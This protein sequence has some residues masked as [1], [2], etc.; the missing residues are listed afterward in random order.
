MQFRLFIFVLLFLFIINPVYAVRS[1]P[2]GV[3]PEAIEG[4]A[5]GTFPELGGATGTLTFMNIG[6]EARL[7]TIC[8]DLSEERTKVNN[9]T[10]QGIEASGTFTGGPDGTAVFYTDSGGVIKLQL[11]D[12]KLFT[13]TTQGISMNF[14]VTDPT[15]FDAWVEPVGARDSGARASDLSGQVEIACPPDLEAWDVMKMGRVIYV[16][17][18]I[19]TGEYIFYD[20]SAESPSGR[21]NICYDREAL[22]SRK[23]HKPENSAIDMAEGIGIEILTAE[24]YKDLQKL[25]NFDTKTSSWIKTPL[26]IRKLGGALFADR[27]YNSVFVYHNGAESYYNSRGFRGSLRV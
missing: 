7:V 15:I 24:Q 21:R 14:T 3:Q 18:H 5:T 25:G 26:G 16:D 22:N 10:C 11:T 2:A 17:C 27:R 19:K 9:L 4:E 13:F 8:G 23:E 1:I 20:C 12:G 6:G